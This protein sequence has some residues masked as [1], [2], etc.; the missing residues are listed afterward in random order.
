MQADVY[1]MSASNQRF[2]G[3]VDSTAFGVTPDPSLVGSLS[4]GLPDVQRR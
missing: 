4:Q 2:S 3:V 1:V